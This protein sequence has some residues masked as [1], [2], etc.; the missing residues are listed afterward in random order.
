VSNAATLS[1]MAFMYLSF[2]EKDVNRTDIHAAKR[3]YFFMIVYLL[4]ID[5]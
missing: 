3:K 4:L 5:N 1:C 2:C